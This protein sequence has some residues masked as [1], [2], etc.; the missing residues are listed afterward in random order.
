MDSFLSVKPGLLFWSL[1]NFV[2]FLVALYLIGGKNFIRNI[3]KREEAIQHAIDAA[4][5]AKLEAKKIAADNEEK[6][7]NVLKVVDDIIKKGKEQA[8][9]QA[10]VIIEQ[11]DK[12]R[13]IIIKQATDEIERSKQ[14]ALKQ[15]REEVADMVVEATEKIIKEKL[16][17]NK[18]RQLI[19]TYIDDLPKN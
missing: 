10:H 6:L 16:D 19:A 12:N 15:I 11:A 5:E 14:S 9:A 4:E 2:F 18:D 13:S 7:I 8:D 3:S 1:V 17:E